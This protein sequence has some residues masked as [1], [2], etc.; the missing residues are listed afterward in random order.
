MYF[1]Y[2]TISE[3]HSHLYSKKQSMRVFPLCP[4]CIVSTKMGAVI[5]VILKANHTLTAVS[6][7][8]TLHISVK[9]SVD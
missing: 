4:E 2:G 9:L 1:N 6:H 7:D 8:S 3:D 5:L